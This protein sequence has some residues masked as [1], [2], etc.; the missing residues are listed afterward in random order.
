MQLNPYLNFNGTCEA[1]L[2]KDGTIVRPLEKTFWAARF[3]VVVDQFGVR[4]LVN[5]DGSDSA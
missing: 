5:C 1:A 2:A 4:W 3:G